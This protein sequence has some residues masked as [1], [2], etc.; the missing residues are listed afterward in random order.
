MI[1]PRC[2]VCLT[3]LSEL[4]P[5]VRR[6][7]ECG[8]SYMRDFAAVNARAVSL[9]ID[10]EHGD[11]YREREARRKGGDLVGTATRAVI[12]ETGRAGNGWLL[13]SVTDSAGRHLGE[14]RTPVGYGAESA[15]NRYRTDLHITT[16]R[17]RSLNEERARHQSAKQE[18]EDR[19]A[20]AVKGIRAAHAAAMASIIREADSA[21]SDSLDAACPRRRR[22]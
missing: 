10:K 15:L 9:G 6:H 4:E 8:A 1:T 12:D 14:T 13:W 5:S 20:E 19:H 3:P 16:R 2:D 17:D 18:E 22:A 21:L 7:R 11:A